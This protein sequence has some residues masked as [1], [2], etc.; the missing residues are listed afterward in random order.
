M[1]LSP[2]LGE[3]LRDLGH[4]AVHASTIGLHQAADAI[5]L[6]HARQENRV[7]LTADLDY[8]RLLAI[9]RAPGPGVILFRGGDWNE[10]QIRNGLERVFGALANA[11]VAT[12]LITVEKHRIRRRSLPITD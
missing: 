12:S 7:V 6:D 2:L 4:E 3:W 5:I 1:P 8:P 11:D 9:T 10:E